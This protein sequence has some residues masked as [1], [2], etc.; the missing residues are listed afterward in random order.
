MFLLYIGYNDIMSFLNLTSLRGF[1][2]IQSYVS[3]NVL[4]GTLP[5]TNSLGLRDF[6]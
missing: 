5:T 2:W 3:L 4:F 1:S 6:L